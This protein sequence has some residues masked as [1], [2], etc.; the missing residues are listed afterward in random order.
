M[1]DIT[2]TRTYIF[3]SD[4]DTRSQQENQTEYLKA[5][6]LLKQYGFSPL[7]TFGKYQGRTEDCFLVSVDSRSEWEIQLLETLIFDKLQQ[8]ALIYQGQAGTYV[9]KQVT[10]S[11]EVAGYVFTHSRSTRA[12]LEDPPA[13]PKTDHT[14]IPH[15]GKFLYLEF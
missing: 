8:D 15:K 7:K 10:Y 3:S 5:E 2:Q 6:Q 13:R 4:K 11:P 14:Y 1:M 12:K 9:L